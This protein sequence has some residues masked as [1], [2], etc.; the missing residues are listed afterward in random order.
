[1]DSYYRQRRNALSSDM[2]NDPM[3]KPTETEIRA[4]AMLAE[5]NQ[6]LIAGVSSAMARCADL[7]GELAVAQAR[8]KELEARLNNPQNGG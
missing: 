6:H 5:L 1:M 3:E 7:A 8:V 2:V 4:R